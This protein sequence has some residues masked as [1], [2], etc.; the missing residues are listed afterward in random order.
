M[1]Q[2]KE[3]TRPVRELQPLQCLFSSFLHTGL[4]DTKGGIKVF[5]QFGHV[6]PFSAFRTVTYN[7]FW[8]E[9]II[10]QERLLF[11]QITNCGFSELL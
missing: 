10:S 5:F 6:S 7:T 2:W 9:M 11:V 3:L 8:E 1:A 4:E